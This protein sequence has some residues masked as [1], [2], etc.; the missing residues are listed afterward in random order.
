M[1]TKILQLAIPF[2]RVIQVIML[3]FMTGFIGVL[4]YSVIDTEAFSNVHLQ[5]TFRARFSVGDFKICPDCESPGS[6][7]LSQLSTY[8]KLWLL[9]RGTALM[10]LALISLQVILRITKSIRDKATFYNRNI[11]GFLQLF[12]L[13]I[14]IAALSSFNFFIQG[15]ESNFEFSIPFGALAYT[16][17]CRLLAE[18]FIEGKMLAEDSNSIV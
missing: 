14:A 5:N 11:K 1:N 4:I 13:G 18:I 9:L 12:R 7:T 16:L 2:F 8:M 6:Y 17:G 10:L 3:V 15:A